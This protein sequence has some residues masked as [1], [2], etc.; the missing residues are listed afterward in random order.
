MSRP[1]SSRSPF[2]DPR[3]LESTEGRQGRFFNPQHFFF[4]LLRETT[5]L[6]FAVDGASEATFMVMHLPI[7][8]NMVVLRDKPTRLCCGAA[9]T[10]CPD[11]ETSSTIGSLGTLPVFLVGFYAVWPEFSRECARDGISDGGAT[12]LGLVPT[13][14]NNDSFLGRLLR[15]RSLLL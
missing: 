2:G 7:P 13:I 1:L 14:D 5:T 11:K 15:Q 12:R 10:D 6:I 3:Q 9:R 4:F 8:W